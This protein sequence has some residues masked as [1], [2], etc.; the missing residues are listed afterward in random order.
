M[1]TLRLVQQTIKMF[2]L[3][4]EINSLSHPTRHSLLFLF[5]IIIKKTRATCSTRTITI[6]IL[7]IH[8]DGYF[9]LC[10]IIFF[11]KRLTDVTG[12]SLNQLLTEETLP[13]TYNFKF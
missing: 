11:D 2:D 5:V 3:T 4:A 7:S 10:L 1:S 13:H 8:Y 6:I 12:I 9:I